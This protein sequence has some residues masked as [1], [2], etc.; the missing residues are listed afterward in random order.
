MSEISEL[1]LL[2]NKQHQEQMAVLRGE[3]QEQMSML[4]EQLKILQSSLNNP[5]ENVPTPMASFQPFDSTSE[6]WTDY[7]ARFRT[8]VTAYSIPDNKQAQI[9]LT[10]QSN[11]VYK[12]LAAQQQP[13]K[14][15]H[16]LT[17]NDIQ[18][19]MAE[20]LTQNNLLSEN[21]SSFGLT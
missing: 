20:Q 9:F 10:N 18:T 11:S 15:I 12:M 1:I 13:V 21:V 4:Q 2:L 3:H 6:L 19:F 14:S 5:R 7:L 17:M 8:F 16:E